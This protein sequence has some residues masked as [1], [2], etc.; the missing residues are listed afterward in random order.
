MSVLRT[1]SDVALNTER[2]PVLDGVAGIHPDV[3]HVTHAGNH[4]TTVSIVDV[5]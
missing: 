3:A 4:V 2:L 5:D 1:A